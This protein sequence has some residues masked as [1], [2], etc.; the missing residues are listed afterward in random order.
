VGI[1]D[2][3][4]G[5]DG[6]VAK[7]EVKDLNDIEDRRVS[8]VKNGT[9]KFILNKFLRLVGLRY[10][11]IEPIERESMSEVLEDLRRGT[12][13]V[14]VSWSPDMN[15]AINEINAL[16][17]NSVKMLITTKEVPNLIPTMLIVNKDYALNN[18]DKVESF[19][20]TWYA[21]SKHI[22]ERPEKAYGNL[23]GLMNKSE[24]Y[25][26]VSKE[27]VEASFKDV[28]LMSLNDNFS[29]FGLSTEDNKVDSI[30]ADTIETWKRYGDLDFD[31]T[32]QE[33]MYDRLFLAEMD[34]D[35]E[36]LVGVLDPETTGS[37]DEGKEFE[38]QDGESI[39]ENTEKVAKVDIPPVY[40]DSGKATV[41]IESLPVLDDVLEILSQFPEYYLIVD[42]HTDS[43]GSNE[44]N[45]LLSQNRAS[46]V[47]KYLV[48]RGVNENR[49]VARGWGEERLL[50]TNDVS[51]EDK[52]KNRRTEFILTREIE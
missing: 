3:S 42:A 30:I 40:Y 2:F 52:A 49:I 23:A 46:E 31:F 25:G 5:A 15:I 50:I 4:R 13:D 44:S 10:Q 22:L 36:L 38:K 48:Q 9:G 51:E 43:V 21:S 28:K 24:E 7:T 20:K 47:K 29:Y 14:I 27:D 34:G 1:T 26:E 19:L 16:K 39:E 6:I 45:K 8:Y 32:I 33:L 18:T 35:E 37:A 11:D 41:K 12:A 17:P